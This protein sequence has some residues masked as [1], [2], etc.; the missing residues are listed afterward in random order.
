MIEALTKSFAQRAAEELQALRAKRL[1]LE[2]QSLDVQMRIDNLNERIRQLMANLDQK[3][4][5]D[6]GKMT[7]EKAET[8]LTAAEQCKA[9]TER[10]WTK[11]PAQQC[12]NGTVEVPTD[13]E[14]AQWDKANVGDSF[15]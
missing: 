7:V 4:L 9:N 14:I 2:R 10:N 5:D 8:I 6:V 15:E 1:E 13:A 3:A 11:R 12:P